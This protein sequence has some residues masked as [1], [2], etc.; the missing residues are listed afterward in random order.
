MMSFRRSLA[1]SRPLLATA[2]V[3]C[4]A[5]L[6]VHA[7]DPVSPKTGSGSFQVGA[8]I[9]VAC[10]VTGSTL[11]F[12]GSIDPLRT[13]GPVDASTNLSVTCTNTT[14][15]SVALSAGTQAP[16]GAFASRAMTSGTH[17]LPYQLYLDA[18]R[19]QV[20]GDGNASGV[21]AGTGTGSAQ[22]L[23]VHGRLPSL[24]GV[25]PGN[26]SDTVTLTITY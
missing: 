5:G 4:S 8:T 16:A 22:S 9:L 1:A 25:V 26:Y 23:T 3:L 12:G 18:G 2:L 11:T 14:P 19:T 7:A 6:T 10:Q 15:Y 21:Y 20:W 13:T 24:A 17:T